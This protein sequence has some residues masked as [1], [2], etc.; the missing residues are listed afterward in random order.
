[1]HISFAKYHGLGNDF[2]VID[3]RQ[4]IFP[5]DD[6][7]LIAHL[8]HRR[9]GIG[10]DGL[11]LLQDSFKADYWMHIFNAD[12]KEAEMCGNGLRCCMAFMRDQGLVRG[13]SRI[14]VSGRIYSCSCIDDLISV[15]MGKV[16]EASWNITVFSLGKE[17]LV[18]CIHTGVPH[19]VVFVEDVD[20]ISVE[21]EGKEIRWHP[22]FQ[23]KGVNANF[24][25]ELP[26][27]M[28]KMRTFERGV[29]RETLAC[30]TGAAAVA[31]AASKMHGYVSPMK[32]L[33][34]SKEVIEI[35][36]SD[37][38]EIEMIGAAT[39]VFK[40]HFAQKELRCITV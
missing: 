7:A 3:D 29:E 15:Q 26:S 1:M 28:L 25:S 6:S 24:V 39:F 4:E 10:A 40:G 13:Q 34:A 5:I 20:Q 14:L 32:I 37:E 8:C 23:P 33:T 27:G 16:K 2:I 36:L 12:G 31:I 11:I 17:I 19:V 35:R 9:T 22:I 38:E 30:G 21:E 18:H